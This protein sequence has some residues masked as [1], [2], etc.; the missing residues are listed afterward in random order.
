MGRTLGGLLAQLIVTTTIF[1]MNMLLM[2]VAGLLRM[3]PTLLPW[4]G[5]VIWAGLIL[6]CRL[7]SLLLA[8]LAPFIRQQ[9][10]INIL[11]GLARFAA[12]L[13][14][15]LL[16]GIAFLFLAQWPITLWTVVPIILHG[17]FVAFIWDEIP[18]EGG[19]RLGTRL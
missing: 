2:S 15:S 11:D 6:S 4:L 3:L 10:R 8:H 19:L 18:A 12:T 9:T 14:L 16:A 13:S 7:Y 17:L 1:T 5:R